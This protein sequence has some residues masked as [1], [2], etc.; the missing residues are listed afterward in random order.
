M[1]PG[2]AVR[3]CEGQGNPGIGWLEAGKVEGSGETR[4]TGGEG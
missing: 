1:Y 2:R 4:V 3:D